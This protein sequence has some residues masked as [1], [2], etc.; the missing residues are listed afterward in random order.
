[1]E[2]ATRHAKRYPNERT[3]GRSTWTVLAALLVTGG[4][5]FMLGSRHRDPTAQSVASVQA[6]PQVRQVPAANSPPP[7]EGQ[8]VVVH[9]ALSA[10]LSPTSTPAES[11]EP[12]LSPEDARE[13]H[14][15]RVR[16]SGPD[17]RGLLDA[18]RQVGQSFRDTLAKKQLDVQFDDWECYRDGCM[19]S[20][21]H[22]TTDLV[23]RATEEI[24]HSPGFQHWNGEKL[25]T[26][27][28]AAS[29]GK[30]E[31]VW[32]LYAPPD[33]QVAYEDPAATD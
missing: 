3:A 29:D 11:P 8:R 5:G 24:T 33:G 31:V 28:V 1:M 23:D 14:T 20:A 27:P 17:R 18:A 15:A 22:A 21:R 4:V 30:T 12:Q 7:P 25:R 32:I 2:Q 10:R 6:P 26:G 13:R 16:G 19:V 9:P